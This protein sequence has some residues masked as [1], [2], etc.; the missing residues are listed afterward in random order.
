MI[1]EIKRDTACFSPRQWYVEGPC[2]VR[3]GTPMFSTEQDAKEVLKLAENMVA[4]K[5][6]EIGERIREALDWL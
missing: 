6:D 2:T 1:I 5:Q 4:E 3:Y